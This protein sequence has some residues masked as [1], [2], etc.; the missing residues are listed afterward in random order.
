[1]P[2]PGKECYHFE[3]FNTL[4]PPPQIVKKVFPFVTKK[5]LNEH[6]KAWYHY[7]NLVY[8]NVCEKI[9]SPQNN[10]CACSSNGQAIP[11]NRTQNLADNQH[12]EYN[13]KTL[14]SSVK[15][16][17][18]QEEIFE[19]KEKSDPAVLKQ[20]EDIG[21]FVKNIFNDDL[22]EV[23]LRSHEFSVMDAGN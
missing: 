5:R 6:G 13:E 9:D 23:V 14:K 3:P 8:K 10:A 7:C 12:T 18:T 4:N 1:M 11:S 16:E 21:I 17:V 20:S 19:N 2:K 22:L 15:T